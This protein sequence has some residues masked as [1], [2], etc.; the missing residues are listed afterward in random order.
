ML[1][2]GLLKDD[3]MNFVVMVEGYY[4]VL[5]DDNVCFVEKLVSK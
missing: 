5:I 2:L 4:R 3:V 1:N